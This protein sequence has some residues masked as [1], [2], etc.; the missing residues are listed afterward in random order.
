MRKILSITVSVDIFKKK[1]NEKHIITRRTAGNAG[2]Y[3]QSIRKWCFDYTRVSYRFLL[4]WMN[5]F[6]VSKLRLRSHSI[7]A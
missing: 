7:Y 2:M 3:Q 1:L 4:E 5:L 6:H